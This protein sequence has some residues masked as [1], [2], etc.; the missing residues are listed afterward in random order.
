[1]DGAAAPSRASETKDVASPSRNILGKTWNKVEQKVEN[2]LKKDE[3]I[4]DSIEDETGTTP[5]DIEEEDLTPKK[6]QSPKLHPLTPPAQPAF[7]RQ[8]SECRDFLVPHEPDAE[9]RR[10]SFATRRVSSSQLRTLQDAPTPSR[11]ALGSSRELGYMGQQFEADNNGEGAREPPPVP[12]M[13]MTTNNN[14]DYDEPF[15]GFPPSPAMSQ[16]SEEREHELMVSEVGTK[17]ILNLS[18]NF[19][20]RAGKEKFFLTY[21]RRPNEWHRVT[22]TIDYRHCELG[23]LEADLKDLKFQRD[24]C[25]RIYQVIRKSLMQIR[26]EETVTNLKLKTKNGQLHID[27]TEDMVEV[28][29]Y[30]HI[31]VLRHI[32]EYLVPRVQESKILFESHLSGYVYQVQVNGR[33]SVKKEIPSSHVLQECLYEIT[34]L[35]ALKNSKNVVRIEGI[36]VDEKQERIKGL[37]V[38]HASEGALADL[39]EYKD[40]RPL[41]SLSRKCRWARDIVR[42]LSE[43]HEAGFVQGDFTLTNIVV[44]SEDKACIIDINHRGCPVGW[45]PPELMAYVRSGMRIS[46]F[47]N[48]KTDLYQ[49]GMVLWALANETVDP[50]RE[51]RPFFPLSDNVPDWYR[52]IVDMCLSEDPAKRLSAKDLLGLFPAQLPKE[53]SIPRSTP[54]V[55]VIGSPSRPEKEY[56]DP[57]AAV[58]LEDISAIS[59]AMMHAPRSQASEISSG[60]TFT[61]ARGSSEFLPKSEREVSPVTQPDDIGSRTRRASD[62]MSIDLE[63]SFHDAKQHLDPSELDY[64]ELIPLPESPA[65]DDSADVV[66]AGKAD[67]SRAVSQSTPAAS[68]LGIESDLPIRPAL[69]RVENDEATPSGEALPQHAFGIEASSSRWITEDVKDD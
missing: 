63:R 37:L 43:I 6:A 32:P 40:D 36:V 54:T 4:L 5:E 42:G 65:L 16:D 35:A 11:A 52:H 46:M 41:L 38:T 61:D 27:V 19:R 66:Q 24:K 20:N 49:L 68:G 23:S 8:N 53:E 17:F 31:S 58:E 55:N 21:A 25:I 69:P 15:E 56:I 9:E 64:P 7:S 45:E 50:E 34:A 13:A 26:F 67:E 60:R 47:I 28:I 30:P 22:I 3:T 62:D 12:P 1:M 10:A 33:T 51:E 59:R 48:L 44:D 18:M 29:N 2:W 57:S 39:L 14:Y